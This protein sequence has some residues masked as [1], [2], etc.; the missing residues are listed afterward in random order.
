MGRRIREG[1]DKPFITKKEVER[2]MVLLHRESRSPKTGILNAEKIRSI[3]L[4][5]DDAGAFSPSEEIF[6][7][8]AK[9]ESELRPDSPKPTFPAFPF[10]PMNAFKTELMSPVAQLASKVSMSVAPTPFDST[11]PGSAFSTRTLPTNTFVYPPPADILNTRFDQH[12]GSQD[13]LFQNQRMDFHQLMDPNLV[14]LDP[15]PARCQSNAAQNGSNVGHVVDN[16]SSSNIGSNMENVSNI[17]DLWNCL[18]YAEEGFSFELQYD[19]VV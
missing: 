17:N 18:P 16:L 1:V 7:P 15:P 6:S 4:I 5:N 10:L 2:E 8:S 14:N 9:Y 13:R 3:P 19:N 12:I 11:I